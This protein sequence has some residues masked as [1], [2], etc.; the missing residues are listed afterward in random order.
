MGAE[1]RLPVVRATLFAGLLLLALAVETR[2]RGAEPAPD[3]EGRIQI[4]LH[5]P[6]L[7]VRESWYDEERSEA[8][9]GG[10]ES[11]LPVIVR[12]LVEQGEGAGMAASGCDGVRV[13]VAPRGV[14]QPIV[15]RV[16]PL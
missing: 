12:E 14:D 10:P 4:R 11:D 16:E 3:G 5:I 7:G 1:V 2:V 6:D 15:L 9:L 8:C 13:P